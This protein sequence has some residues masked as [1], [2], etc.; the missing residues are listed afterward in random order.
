VRTQR[1]LEA[2]VFAVCLLGAVL[3]GYRL[4]WAAAERQAPPP[5]TLGAR[6]PPPAESASPA[7]PAPAPPESSPDGAR[8]RLALRQLLDQALTTGAWT[9]DDVQRFR[10]LAPDVPLPARV[11][12]MNALYDAIESHRL[13]RR[14]RGPPM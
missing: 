5:A 13:A 8:A 7:P 14:Y 10:R 2:L 1:M 11:E 12:L 6:T 3:V 9:D 4:G